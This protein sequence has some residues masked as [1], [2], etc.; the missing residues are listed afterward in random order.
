VCVCVCASYLY[1][2]KLAKASESSSN[3]EE[4]IV[5]DMSSSSGTFMNSLPNLY[6]DLA[7]KENV[8]DP[9]DSFH[10]SNPGMKQPKANQNQLALPSIMPQPPLTNAYAHLNCS[11]GQADGSSQQDYFAD[12]IFTPLSTVVDPTHLTPQTEC[13]TRLSQLNLEMEPYQ[14][15]FLSPPSD[16]PSPPGLQQQQKSC[17]IRISNLL[18]LRPSFTKA[19][20]PPKCPLP[21]LQWTSAERMWQ[22]MRAKDSFKAVPEAELCGSHPEIL[23]SMRII[24]LDW[25]MEV[26]FVLF[27]FC[28]L[29]VS[30]RS[31]PAWLEYDSI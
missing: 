4:V 3:V 22:T 15:H 2:Q 14:S 13:S 17:K 12:H 31:F 8:L 28:F 18:G 9:M 20:A 5:Q 1:K 7:C 21:T 25:M 24:L 10:Q 26:G 29:L 30:T 11:G 6:S 27:F 19:T 16:S 23:S